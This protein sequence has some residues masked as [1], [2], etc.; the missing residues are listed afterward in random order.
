MGSAL[1]WEAMRAFARILKRTSGF[2]TIGVVVVM[3]LVGFLALAVGIG[4]AFAYRTLKERRIHV[5]RMYIR[6]WAITQLDCPLTLGWIGADYSIGTEV[7]GRGLGTRGVAGDAD[8]SLEA[9]PRGPA[10]RTVEGHEV[11]VVYE[12]GP[13][14]VSLRL[15]ARPVGTANWVDLIEPPYWTCEY[16]PGVREF[17]LSRSLVWGPR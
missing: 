15:Q 16:G 6:H 4:A 3:G 17:M 5:Q 12:S 13:T 8:W 11:R 1:K 7:S 10:Y 9:F 14:P 2:E